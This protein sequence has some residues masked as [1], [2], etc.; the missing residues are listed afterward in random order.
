MISTMIL[1]SG[2]G[3][4]RGLIEGDNEENKNSKQEFSSNQRRNG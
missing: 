1:K 4:G 2:Y 3:R